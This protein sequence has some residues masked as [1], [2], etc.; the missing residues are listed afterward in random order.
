MRILELS[1][2]PVGP[3]LKPVFFRCEKNCTVVFDDNEAGK[4]SLVDIIVNLLF[5]RTTAQSRF[6]SKRFD[7]YDGY[8]KIEHH[9]E[10]V[11]YTGSADLDQVLGLPPEFSRLPIVRGGDLNFLWSSNKERKGPLIEACI[12]HFSAD[13]EES[14]DAVIRAIRGR[15]GLP[16]KRNCWT[17]G[18]V[19]ELQQQLELYRK[20]EALL[21]ALAEQEQA[22]QEQQAAAGMLEAVR[23]EL[24][25]IRAEMEL[26]EDERQAALYASARVEESRLLAL[27]QRYLEGGYER[28]SHEDLNAWTEAAAREAFLLEQERSLREQ[29]RSLGLKISGLTKQQE[30]L[31]RRLREADA[32][33]RS[34]RARLADLR[35]EDEQ[36]KLGCADALT[37]AR[38]YLQS[39]LR[40][41]EQRSRVKWA[42]VAVP[43]LAVAAV[44]LFA[45]GL[46]LPGGIA[47]FAVLGAAAWG[48]AVSSACSRT[49][50]EAEERIRQ[51][52]RGY[53]VQSAGSLE[54]GVAALERYFR[55]DEARRA[56]QL[57]LADQECSE[58]GDL[59]QQLSREGALA[60]QELENITADLRQ[61]E[62]LLAECTSQLEQVQGSLQELRRRTGKPDR[63]SLED[64][65]QEK[66]RLERE[67]AGVETRL[68]TLLGGEDDWRERLLALKSYLE[69]HPDPRSL[70]ELEARMAFLVKR[71]QELTAQEEGLEQRCSSLLQQKMEAARSL[72]AVGCGDVAG[73]ALQLEKAEHVLKDAIRDSLA[74]L[75]AQQAIERAQEEFEDLLLEPLERAGELFYRITGRYDTLT[76]SRENGDAVFRAAGD[77][78]EYDEDA[79]SDGTRAQLLLALRLALLEQISGD[80]PGFLVLDDPLLNSSEARKR[81]AV[82]VLLDYARQGWQVF[83]LTVDRLAAE[84]FR[85]LGEDLVDVKRVGDFWIEKPACGNK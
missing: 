26:L 40:S 80:E 56:E 10:E 73:L 50:K 18:K 52:L 25:G 27:K 41:G 1:C 11:T 24:A 62:S 82:K 34:A 21:A 12:Q 67:C 46:F 49:T 29:V 48:L 58:L 42:L 63:A 39:A 13:L 28:C 66:E 83:Y 9:G 6:Q 69:Q 51:L 64:A 37:E 61:A 17:K 8:I 71:E 75:W 22:A 5:R 54:S 74:A 59:L 70:D 53:G 68:K 15:T 45:A 72:Y 38:L 60:D 2:Q 23:E 84:A 79:L 57:R 19:E 36:R 76:C 20:R 30:E 85:E 81:N 33:V 3:L 7:G 31:A 77:G 44:S 32:A 47:L 16:A 14:L 43:L 78:V 55:E 35:R 65:L 4:T